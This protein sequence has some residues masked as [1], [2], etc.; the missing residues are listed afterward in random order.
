M[1]EGGSQNFH[2]L[3]SHQILFT[4][5]TRL[6]AWFRVL[7]VLFPSTPVASDNYGKCSLGKSVASSCLSALASGNYE[8]NK[9]SRFVSAWCRSGSAPKRTFTYAIQWS[10]V[11]G[12]VGD[13][14]MIFSFFPFV[15]KPSKWIEAFIPFCFTSFDSSRSH[16]LRTSHDMEEYKNVSRRK[17]HKLWKKETPWKR[18]ERGG[19]G[20]PPCSTGVT[21]MIFTPPHPPTIT[22]P[23]T[24]WAMYVELFSPPR[25]WIIF[26]GA[27][28]SGRRSHAPALCGRS[29]GGAAGNAAICDAARDASQVH[30]S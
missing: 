30:V 1:T 13:Y 15:T 16:P 10:L 7:L 22:G 24:L 2:L 4:A 23:L 5:L 27:P 14:D 3:T 29:S 19:R 20:A 17:K 18:N 26:L 12:V 9:P 8:V 11:L 28:Y 21:H 25:V 6:P